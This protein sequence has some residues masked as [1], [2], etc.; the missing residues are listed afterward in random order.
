MD[1]PPPN[2]QI[3]LP[4]SQRRS[5]GEI[6]L[7]TLVGVGIPFIILWLLVRTVAVPM[8]VPS[9]M[10]LRGPETGLGAASTPIVVSVDLR[11]PTD[12]PE[13]TK[14]PYIPLLTPVPPPDFCDYRYT[15][16]GATC[17][18]PDPPPPTPSP[19]PFCPLPGAP[20]PEPGERCRMP[21]IPTP[22][23]APW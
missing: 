14:A 23:L 17:E 1:Y 21:V 18:W 9:E 7:L 13:P 19:V 8:S 5:L 6:A 16:A 22:E 2:T 12:T 15:A 10:P 11:W 4:Q 3:V 20:T